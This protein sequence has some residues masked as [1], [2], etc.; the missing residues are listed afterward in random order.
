MLLMLAFNKYLT[1][2]DPLFQAIRLVLNTRGIKSWKSNISSESLA[3]T[4]KYYL[5]LPPQF[6]SNYQISLLLLSN[7]FVIPNI[8]FRKGSHSMT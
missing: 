3:K 6:Q 4:R 2:S 1:A 7:H 5:N 8:M